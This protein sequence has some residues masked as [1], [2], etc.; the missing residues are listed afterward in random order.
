MNRFRPNIVIDESAEPW[1]E[2]NWQALAFAGPP[3]RR[4]EFVSLKPCSRCKVS[5]A[6]EPRMQQRPA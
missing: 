2:D 5:G 4:V 1:A 3:D 6:L